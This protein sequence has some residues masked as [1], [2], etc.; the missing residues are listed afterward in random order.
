[1]SHSAPAG[2]GGTTAVLGV[3]LF[4]GLATTGIG[5][6]KVIWIAVAGLASILTGMI[7][8]GRGR[9]LSSGE[10]LDR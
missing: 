7:T 8:L 5:F 6:G 3:K 1:M 9:R 10:P 4:K 2:G